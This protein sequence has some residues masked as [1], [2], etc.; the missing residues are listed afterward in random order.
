MAIALLI[1]TIAIY[2]TVTIAQRR[3]RDRINDSERERFNKELDN[4]RAFEDENT[5][6]LL[7]SNHAPTGPR[8]S[9]H[10]AISEAV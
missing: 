2:A 5:V 10:F 8:P 7:T 3:V 9:E 4:L 6:I 1:L